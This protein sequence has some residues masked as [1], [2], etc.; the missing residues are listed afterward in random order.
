VRIEL[1]T[2]QG[3]H[4][5]AEAEQLLLAAGV[6]FQSLDV[7][8]DETLFRLYD[9]RVPLVLV[10]GRVVAEGHITGAGLRQ[11]LAGV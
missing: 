4:L 1:I 2:R 11:A 10:E 7:D 9:F 5:C 3:C 6:R 8:S